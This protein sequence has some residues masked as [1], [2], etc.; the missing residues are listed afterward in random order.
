MLLDCRAC[1][2]CCC[3]P[4]QNRADGFHDWVEVKRRDA[5]LREPELVRRFVILN[6][7][8]APHLRLA[9]GGRCAALEGRV[10]RRVSCTIYEHRPS[11][12][13][14]VQPG[15]ARCLEYRRERSL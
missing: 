10:G 13:R 12:C 3:N 4:A 5:I 9:P 15:D 14:R 2:A 8:G 11:P 6:A 1:G 7:E